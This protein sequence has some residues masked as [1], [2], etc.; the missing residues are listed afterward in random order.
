MVSQR[1]NPL[2]LR[3]NGLDISVDV[4]L[5]LKEVLQT[6]PESFLMFKGQELYALEYCNPPIG[7]VRYKGKP[8]VS[9]TQTV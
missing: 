9:F 7:F 5:G 3:E 8:Q 4:C 6:F 1:V 2:P